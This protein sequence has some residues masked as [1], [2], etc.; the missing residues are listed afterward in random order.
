M[1]EGSQALSYRFLAWL[2]ILSLDA[3]MVAIAWLFLVDRSFSIELDWIHYLMLANSVWLV[4]AG[5]RLVDGFRI[6]AGSAVSPRR[7]F[8][9]KRRKTLFILLT[10]SVVINTVLTLFVLN[11]REIAYGIGLL[12][13]V[14]VYL[15]LAHVPDRFGRRV[16]LKEF[17]VALLFTAG[18]LL[19]PAAALPSVSALVLPAT[20]MF[21]VFLAN[22]IL[23][24]YWEIERDREEG[25]S[26]IALRFPDLADTLPAALGILAAGSLLIALVINTVEVQ[27]LLLSVSLGAFFLLLLHLLRNQ[28]DLDACRTLADLA[29]LSPLIII[30]FV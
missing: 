7:R 24:S 16:P 9:V 11:S 14:L 2:G 3:P 19:F 27:P 10:L 12:A 28:I 26:S 30:M 29:L 21:L 1:D 5:D 25:L 15:I 23:I 8:A 17:L 6:R 4:Y 18:T 13:V 20:A 22:C